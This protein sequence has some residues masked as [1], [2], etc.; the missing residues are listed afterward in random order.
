MSHVKFTPGV[1]HQVFDF[2]KLKVDCMRAEERNCCLT[3]DECEIEPGVE[4]D[5][6]NG[7]ILG[8]STF[9]DASQKASKALVFMLSGK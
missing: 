2:M 9:P 4:F 5:P 6:S 8:A 3:L 1:L 7:C